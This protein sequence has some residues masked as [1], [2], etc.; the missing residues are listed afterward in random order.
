MDD[1][2][3]FISVEEAQAICNATP[4]KPR[5]ENLPLDRCSG[6]V[7]AEDLS[8][9]VDDPPFDNSSMDG[10]AC[11]FD[12]EAT[13][14]LTLNI[15]GLQAATGQNEHRHNG[16][17]SK[18]LLQGQSHNRQELLGEYWVKTLL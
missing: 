18:K 6:R 11:K 1:R 7:L 9:Q 4:V 8:S 16:L 12:A 5:V 10:F 15:V 13:Y 2:P 14:P 17:G 3:Y